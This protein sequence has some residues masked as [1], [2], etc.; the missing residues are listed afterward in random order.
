MLPLE[1][2]CGAHELAQSVCPN[3]RLCARAGD[4]AQAL[5]VALENSLDR[6]EQPEFT[7]GFSGHCC[8][9]AFAVGDCFKR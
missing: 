4:V 6:A 2:R 3:V 9:K 7:A 5:K 8:T 1:G